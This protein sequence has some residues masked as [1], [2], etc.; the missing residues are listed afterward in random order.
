METKG[1]KM[2]RNMET[3]WI[4]MQSLAQRIMSEFRTLLVKMAIDMSGAV[5]GRP[6]TTTATNFDYLSD[7]EVLLSL[8]CFIPMLNVVY[9]LIKLSHARYIFICDFLQAVKLCQSDLARMFVDDSIAFQTLEFHR[10]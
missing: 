4:S 2:L 6:S 10:Y 8:S 3:R 1:N 7:I 5:G 9:C